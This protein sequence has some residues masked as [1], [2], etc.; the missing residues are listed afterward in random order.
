M[1]R[2]GAAVRGTWKW[3]VVGG[4]WWFLVVVLTVWLWCVVVVNG[5]V[6]WWWYVVVC[7]AGCCGDGKVQQVEV[8]VPIKVES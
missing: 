5:G 1:V 7:D 4:A 8:C 6:A 2:D 3:C